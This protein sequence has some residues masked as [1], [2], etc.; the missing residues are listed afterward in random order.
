MATAGRPGWRRELALRFALAILP[1]TVLVVY[2][3]PVLGRGPVSWAVPLGMALGNALMA[4]TVA[5]EI[6]GKRRFLVF[7]GIYGSVWAVVAW[8]GLHFHSAPRPAALLMNLRE[9]SHTP[10]PDWTEIPWGILGAVLGL[11]WLARRSSPSGRP[12][13]LATFAAVMTFFALHTAAFLRYRTSDMLRFSQYSDLI[14]TQGLEGAAVLDALELL[15]A[16]DTARILRDLRLQAAAHPPA[17]L[18]LEPIAS[19]RMVII[20]LESLDQEAISPD[21]APTL[22][23]LRN[24]ATHGLV[25][26]L[27][28]SVSGSSCADFQLLTGLRAFAGVPVYRLIWDGDGSG[29]PA[30]AASHRF[31]FHVYHGNERQFW[32]R[33]PFL[34]A[35]GANFHALED[36]PKT[37]FS[38]WGLADGDLFRYAAAHIETTGR[39]VHF[40][41]TLSTHAP[42]D[43]VEPAADLDGATQRTRY[44]HSVAYLD[45]VLSKFLEALPREGTTLVV[46][47]SDHT[48][49]LFGSLG[50]DAEPAV[51]M[52]LGRL[53]P[54]G[55]LAPLSWRG[56][57]VRALPDTYEFPALY[58]YI[59]DCLDASAH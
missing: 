11:G 4:V 31:A 30:Y 33:G 51:P 35:M 36:I 28:T 24:G 12:L 57:P 14:R 13:R 49:N 21:A 9:I 41:I 22:L 46:I 18:P 50:A 6:L 1:C 2:L 10:L 55:S 7:W 20:Q 54:D 47:Y 59:K 8:H 26:P 23:R 27:R 56:R 43:L 52:I 37:E 19:D 45:G 44:F 38:R 58:R 5:R 42:F 34:S 32:N 17:L 3:R 53:A 16:P 29:L 15:R 48:S 25:N 40:L 39:A